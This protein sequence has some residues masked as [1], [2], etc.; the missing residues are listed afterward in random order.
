MG[1][2]LIIAFLSKIKSRPVRK[3]SI[4]PLVSLIIAAYNEE[5]IIGEKIENTLSLDYPQDLLEVIIVSDGSMDE[6]E[7]IARQFI[8]EGVKLFHYPDRRG[9]PYALNY[10]VSH[11]RGEVLVFS[12]ANVLCEKDAIRKVVQNFSD[13]SVGCVTGKILLRPFSTEEPLGEGFYMRVEGFIHRQE[14]LFSTMI[15]TDG[16]MYAIRKELF[17]PLPEETLVDDFVISMRVLEKGY[18]IVYEP[19][20]RGTEMVP[21]SVGEEFKR[22][23]RIIAGGY[24]SIWMLRSLLNP[25]RYPVISLEFTSHKL[26]RWFSPFLM[27][28]LF[29]SSLFLIARPL[30]LFVFCLQ[31]AFY[32]LAFIA[33]IYKDTRNRV[34]VYVPYYLCAT[35]LAAIMGAWGWLSGRQRVQWRKV[36]R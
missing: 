20:A 15:G 21:A 11:A 25:F 3:D 9:K 29:L 5:K 16:A 1:S 28:M 30:Y 31:L 32:L 14:S 33:L 18:R 13:P 27:S 34:L 8:D 2:P 10:A 19:E 36:A 24:Q 4:T 7:H 23:V 26:L 6:T 22:K 35:H 17:K 12:D